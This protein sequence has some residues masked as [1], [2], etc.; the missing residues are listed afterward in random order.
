MMT[1]GEAQMES[2]SLP[3]GEGEA[4][5]WP[6]G[7]MT[8]PVSQAGHS[9]PNSLLWEGGNVVFEDLLVSHKYAT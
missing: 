2:H 4:V 8:N 1:K 7:G 3:G 9:W 5:G 6:G